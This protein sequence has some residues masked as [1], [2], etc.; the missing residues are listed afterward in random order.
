MN[1]NG[2]TKIYPLS[3]AGMTF[4]WAVWMG[5]CIWIHS[6]H[7]TYI[8]SVEA[9]FRQQLATNVDVINASAAAVNTQHSIML[10]AVVLFFLCFLCTKNLRATGT[11]ALGFSLM[12]LV[13][14]KF[15]TVDK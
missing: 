1:A 13:A 11:I 6:A 2:N 3:I 15:I 4:V 10:S 12:W 8:E 9:K 14:T 7:V 5:V